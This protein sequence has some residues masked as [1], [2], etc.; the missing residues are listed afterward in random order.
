MIVGRLAQFPLSIRVRRRIHQSKISSVFFCLFFSVTGATYLVVSIIA[1]IVY[2]DSVQDSVILSIQTVWVQQAIN[3]V[4]AVHVFLSITIMIN[5]I[6]QQA[7]EKLNVPHGANL[8]TFT[9]NNSISP[10][11]INCYFQ[12]RY[13]TSVQ[14]NCRNSFFSSEFGWRRVLTRCGTIL[15]VVIVAE[16]FPRFGVVLDLVSLLEF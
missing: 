4:I 3:I 1:Y 15:A 11:F 12:W 16:T 2:G 14:N 5:P 10:S 13:T 6:N 7:E 9:F 8:L